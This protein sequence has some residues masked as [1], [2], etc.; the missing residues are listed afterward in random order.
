[1]LRKLLPRTT[2]FFSIFSKHAALTA[3]AARLV[4]ELLGALGE[5]ESYSTR[6]RALEHQADALCQEAME[7][8]HR[9]FVTP[10]ERS[11]IH[12]LASALDDIT[13]QVESCAQRLWLYEIRVATPEMGPMVDHLCRATEA[14][15]ETVDALADRRNSGRLRLLCSAVKQVEKENDRLLRSATARL[16]REEQDAKT[17][18]KWKEIY[19]AVEGAIDSCEDVANVI[20]GVVLENA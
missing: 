5:A 15:R 3:E 19:D 1:M 6:I 2:D 4:R 17:L 11:D 8:L 16:F 20:E 14:V 12:A 13:D 7:K 9:T 10:I 18:I